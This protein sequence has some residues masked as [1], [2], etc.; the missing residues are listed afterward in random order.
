MCSTGPS[1]CSIF[2]MFTKNG[3]FCA[4]GLGVFNCPT[5]TLEHIRAVMDPSY[6]KVLISQWI[7]PTQRATSFMTHQDFN[8]MATFSAMDRTEEQI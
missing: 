8:M 5:V 7:V 6:S 4:R 2:G 3:P 1:D